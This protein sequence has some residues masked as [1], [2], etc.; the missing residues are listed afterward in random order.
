MIYFCLQLLCYVLEPINTAQPPVK[1]DNNF[2]QDKYTSTKMAAITKEGC[3]PKRYILSMLVFLGFFTMY[4]LR[5]NL[6]VAIGA[7]AKNHTILS[8]GKAHKEVKRL[9]VN[10]KSLSRST[11]VAKSFHC[12]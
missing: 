7:M 2:T 10:V 12:F 4:G 11:R 8:H 3:L 5:V 1:R 9:K 6:N